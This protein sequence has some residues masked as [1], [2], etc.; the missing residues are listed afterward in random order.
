MSELVNSAQCVE[1]ENRESAVAGRSKLVNSTH[2]APALK[3]CV[4]EE[5]LEG[6]ATAW[7]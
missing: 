6:A 4:E 3:M 1:E 2:I 5:N 7:E